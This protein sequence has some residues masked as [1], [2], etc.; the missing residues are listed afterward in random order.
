MKK[1]VNIITLGCSK[2][3]VDSETI[4][5]QLNAQGVEFVFDKYDT[6]CKTVVINTCGFINDAKEESINTILDFVE[7]KE[8][9]EIENLYVIG[10]L[11]E[12]YKKD[13]EREIPEVDK[14]F[15]V[16]DIKEIVESLK[17][18]YKKELLGERV[19]STP[20]HYAYLKISEGCD[21]TCAFCSIPGIRGKHISVPQETL[22]AQAKYLVSNG[23]KEIILIAQDLSYYGLDTAKKQLLPELVENLAKIEGLK[24][25][26]L[27]YAYPANFPTELLQVMKKYDIVAK[28]IDIPIQH[29]SDNVLAKMRRGHN[30]NVILELLKQF[31][32]EMPEMAVR[33]TLL[34][35]HPGET[36]E[37]FDELLQFVQ[38]YK[39][40]RLGVFEYSHEDNTFGAENY[41]DNIPKE[42]KKQRM[43]QLLSVQQNIS[44]ELN[45]NKIG[46]V[47]EVIIDKINGEYF[48]GRTQFDSPE[49]DNEVLIPN[50]E[51]LQ[52]GEIYKVKI[53]SAQEFDL[54]GEVQL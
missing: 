25:I 33:T 47:F 30:K 44:L 48:V 6:N 27:H 37:D 21:R 12:R 22:L 53:I 31:R 43:E 11:S 18:N 24:I 3:L 54:Y 17:V 19:I 26:R 15:G 40:D 9:G 50:T 51:K 29:I 41:E 45:Q 49:V 13:L 20:K 28:Y 36:Q 38:Q 8:R 39:F 23:V 5:T 10:C 52:I 35:G 2:N 32:S 7:A 46:K 14:Y 42:I 34:V 1:K 16:T 4:A